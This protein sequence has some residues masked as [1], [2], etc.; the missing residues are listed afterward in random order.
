MFV[1]PMFSLP[2]SLVPGYLGVSKSRSGGHLENMGKTWRRII[3]EHP[4]NTEFFYWGLA[5]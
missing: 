3:L 1:F 4:G 5:Y 2:S